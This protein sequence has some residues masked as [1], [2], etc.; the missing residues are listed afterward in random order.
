[1]RFFFILM[2]LVISMTNGALADGSGNKVSVAVLGGLSFPSL[3]SG[4][5]GYGVKG[6]YRIFPRL[7]TSFFYYKY[8]IGI[9]TSTGTSTLQASTSNTSFGGEG[10]LDFSDGFSAG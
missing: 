9:Q 7:L 3:S 10:M 1:M 4:A 2:H 8:G 6:G 5:F